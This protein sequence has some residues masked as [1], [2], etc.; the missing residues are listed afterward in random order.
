MNLDLA[1][2]A[3][4]RH[5]LTFFFIA[6]FSR[7]MFIET[8]RLRGGKVKESCYCPMHVGKEVAPHDPEM[9]LETGSTRRVDQALCFWKEDP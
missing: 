9:R 4:C 3:A 2:A 1:K 6:L 5:E 7:G 8:Y